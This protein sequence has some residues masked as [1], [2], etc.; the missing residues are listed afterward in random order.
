GATPI[1]VVDP[2]AQLPWRLHDWRSRPA[3][4]LPA[5]L[6]ALAG[7]ERASG[8]DI[9]RAPLMKV[10]LVLTSD[11]EAQLFWTWHHIL[12]D[13]WSAAQVIG[14]LMAGYQSLTAGAEPPKVDRRPY[15]DYIA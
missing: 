1:Q 15:R 2:E 8:F 14:E 13:G 7:E 5:G 6:L 12:L 4:S 3:A 11:E 10:A 9:E